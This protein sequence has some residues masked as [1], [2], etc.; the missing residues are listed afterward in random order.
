MT[1]LLD[2]DYR[3]GHRAAWPVCY[4]VDKH[5]K[6]ILPY[7][8]QLV[9]IAQQKDVHPAVTRNI[10]R[11][12]Q[13][14]NVPEELEGELIEFCFQTLNDRSQPVAIR[15]FAITVASNICCKY[16]ELEKE[17]YIIIQ[18]QLPYERPAFK[19]RASK[20]LRTRT[21]QKF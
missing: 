14:I 13:N 12:L 3:V 11:L 15:T 10:L 2:G 1:L 6:L 4:C 20:F 8:S 7:L 9:S 17:L 21:S 5:P 19:S 16:P 18:D